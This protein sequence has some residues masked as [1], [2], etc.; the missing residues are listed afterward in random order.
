[1]PRERRQISDKEEREREE[2]QIFRGMKKLV[3]EIF[4]MCV[5]VNPVFFPP[6]SIEFIRLGEMT[7]N[8]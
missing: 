1:M 4:F 5:Q 7:D 6:T 3:V 2:S 8:V